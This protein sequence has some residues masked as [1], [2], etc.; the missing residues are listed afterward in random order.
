MGVLNDKM[1]F[2]SFRI[3]ENS[4]LSKEDW[5]DKGVMGHQIIS[6]LIP[7]ETKQVMDVRMKA[8]VVY[9]NSEPFF[10]SFVI[11]KCEIFL[12]NSL[13]DLIINELSP[14]LSC[15]AIFISC[16]D[17]DSIL[18]KLFDN[19]FSGYEKDFFRKKSHC[20]IL[21]KTES[22]FHKMTSNKEEF[23]ISGNSIVEIERE[24]DDTS[25]QESEYFD[26]LTSI[27]ID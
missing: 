12:C 22:I 2:E 3:V 26:C 10:T 1:I 14:N 5:S 18:F 25:S 7:D 9:S 17:K 11:E 23:C 8:Y 13:D 4:F 21:R 6:N 15:D 19:S 27:T 24:E 16:R 20:E